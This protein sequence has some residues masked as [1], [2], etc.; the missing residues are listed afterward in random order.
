MK[1]DILAFGAHPDDIELGAGGTIIKEVALGRKVGIIDLTRGELGTRGSAEERD[2]ESADA[3]ELLGVE[4]RA[5]MGFR[6]GFFRN[7]E[8]NQMAL[9]PY[10]RH[11]QPEIVICNAKSDRHTDHG[12]AGDLVS[13]ACFLSGLARITTHWDHVVQEAWR[14]KAVYHYIQDR[15]HE[16]DFV[17]DI[18]AQFD[19]KMKAVLSFKSQFYNPDSSE[20]ETPISSKSFLEFLQGRA[21][22][23]GRPAG[24]QYAEGFT[25]ERYIGI[26]TLFS[27]R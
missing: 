14:P 18:S 19:M 10:I 20:P 6:D 15:F 24:Y 26:E 3:A 17:L 23:L 5:N 25:V 22:S 4:F 27:I 13:I 1:L 9:I 12:K 2:R 16:P 11:F 7:D 8:E 21:V